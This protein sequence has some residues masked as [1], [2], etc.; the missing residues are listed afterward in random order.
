MGY[1]EDYNLSLTQK[2]GKKG[3]FAKVST[4]IFLSFKSRDLTALSLSSL[5]GK[6]YYMYILTQINDTLYSLKPQTQHIRIVIRNPLLLTINLY[7]Y[8]FF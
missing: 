7:S 3:R 4:S 8:I 1:F 6:C 2:L 5:F